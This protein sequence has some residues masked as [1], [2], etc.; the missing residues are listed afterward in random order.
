MSSGILLASQRGIRPEHRLLQLGRDDALLP[1]VRDPPVQITGRRQRHA[2]R[3]MRVALLLVPCRVKHEPVIQLKTAHRS[4][5]SSTP[6]GQP[7][8]PSAPSRMTA[9]PPRPPPGTGTAHSTTP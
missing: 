3:R 6:R 8:Y 1:S 5:L 7:P 9:A 4:L 2:H